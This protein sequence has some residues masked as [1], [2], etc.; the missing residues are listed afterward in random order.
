MSLVD[1][2][3]LRQSQ[4]YRL[5]GF[6]ERVFTRAAIPLDSVLDWWCRFVAFSGISDMILVCNGGGQQRKTLRI[7]RG[8]KASEE[9]G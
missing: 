2:V 8:S 9:T 1:E 4:K 6:E 5:K 7:E 3:S